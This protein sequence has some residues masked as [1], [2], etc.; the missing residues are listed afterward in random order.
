MTE[1]IK[2]LK[3]EI[4]QLKTMIDYDFLT[5]LYNRQGFT[6]E[7]EKFLE[8]FK[9]R[10]KIKEKRKIS[11]KNFSL[12]FIDIDNLKLIN[13]GYGHRAGDQALKNAANV[14]K[15]SIRDFDI[16]ARWGGDE[17]VIGLVGVNS[18]EA[19]KITEKTRKKLK[20]IKINSRNLSASFG[21]AA[22]LSEKPKKNIFNLYELIEKADMT[23][24]DAKKNKGKD[25]VAVYN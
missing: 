4:E 13:D 3:K 8:E 10:D 22:V 14:F 7:A 9:N 21:V 5:G 23:M 19:L 20:S 2:K 25:F 24:Y 15:N 6:K 16:A 12:I 11:F 18:K 17:F 1:T